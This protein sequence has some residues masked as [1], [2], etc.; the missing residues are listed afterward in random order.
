MFDYLLFWV[1]TIV[2]C[3]ITN[4]R[5]MAFGF[6]ILL[7]WFSV[8]FGLRPMTLGTDTST[9]REIYDMWS[10]HVFD[11]G[12]EYFF[13]TIFYSFNYLGFDYLYV[14]FFLSFIFFLFVLIFIYSVYGRDAWLVCMLLIGVFELW[15]YTINTLRYGLAFSFFLSALPFIL[16]SSRLKYFYILF[17]GFLS[18]GM[19]YSVAVLWFFLLSYSDS[20]FSFL[21]RYFLFFIVPSLLAALS[22]FDVVD[23]LFNNLTWLFEY[24]PGRIPDKLY[25]YYNDHEMLSLKIG[26]SYFF[27]FFVVVC[28]WLFM[29]RIVSLICNDYLRYSIFKI[30]FLFSNAFLI[31]Y[32]F[33]SDYDVFAR[34]LSGLG[35]FYIFLLIELILSL[36]DR[37]SSVF[38]VLFIS[39]LLFLKIVI[40]GFSN[41]FLSPRF[42]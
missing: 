9:Y 10:F 21:R 5:A 38:I 7:F 32:P 6:V 31:T 42:L 18:F 12:L 33:F 19:H 3:F 41:G 1:L 4:S 36:F 25:Q 35:F 24:L 37:R 20:V 13:S 22:S 28:V 29:G 15:S 11:S 16:L 34:A 2:I 8:F 23:F 39:F 14:Q 30:A 40:V 17:F 27:I 26:F